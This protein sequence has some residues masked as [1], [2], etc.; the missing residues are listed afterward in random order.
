MAE[1]RLGGAR[2][3][4]GTR[5]ELGR[6]GRLGAGRA[7]RGLVAGDRL[8]LELERDR[9]GDAGLDLQAAEAVGHAD[10]ETFLLRADELELALAF[11]RVDRETSIVLERDDELHGESS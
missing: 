10:R 8:A 11:V 1:R 3:G 9:A 7:R 2:V 6:L 5:R 4:A